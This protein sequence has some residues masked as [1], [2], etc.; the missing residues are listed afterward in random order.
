[1]T[2]FENGESQKSDSGFVVKIPPGKEI[3]LVKVGSP[4]R[5][6]SMNDIEDM[7]KLIEEA[8][9]TDGGKAIVTHHDVTIDRIA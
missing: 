4:D 7:K 2:L 3:Y 9:L 6:A 1:M 5:P 8:F